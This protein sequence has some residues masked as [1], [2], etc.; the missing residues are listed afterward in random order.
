MQRA[1][2]WAETP[3]FDMTRPLRPRAARRAA[4]GAG[5]GLPRSAARR[6]STGLEGTGR[7]P[8]SG[9]RTRGGT[10]YSTRCGP[11][12]VA[13]RQAATKAAAEVAT[14]LTAQPGR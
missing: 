11:L 14:S 7:R 3:L 13:A 5:V 2:K 12:S 1:G 10:P 6:A 4:R 9:R 8:R